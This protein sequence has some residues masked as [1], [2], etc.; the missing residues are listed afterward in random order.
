MTDPVGVKQ[1]G[2]VIAPIAGAVGFDGIEFICAL[3]DGTD[4]QP[5]E[6][7]TMKEQ[8]VAGFKPLKLVLVPF[9]V[10]V[11]PPGKAVTVQSP[12]EGRPDNW[13]EAVGVEHVGCVISPNVGAEGSVHDRVAKLPASR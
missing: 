6:F 13:T 2:C 9:P 5:P 10:I 8:L 4:K 12:A 1:E 11:A 3:T 7:V